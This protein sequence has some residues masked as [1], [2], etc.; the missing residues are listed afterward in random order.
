MRATSTGGSRAPFD[1]FV[2]GA[3]LSLFR[4]AF[5]MTGSVSDAEDA[6][7]ETLL[8]VARRWYRVKSME[9]PTGYARRIL[10]NVVLDG[11]TRRS[12]RNVELGV[13]DGEPGRDDIR[14][15]AAER[16]LRAAESRIDMAAALC[17]LSPRQRAVIVLRYWDDQSES[18]IAATLGCSV[19]TVKSTASRSVARLRTVVLRP[20]VVRSGSADGARAT[21]RGPANTPKDTIPHSRSAQ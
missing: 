20:P 15:P 4:T 18:E 6:V 13:A 3:T 5:L 11:A 7:Q 17:V 16:E 1:A 10:V 21:D 19:G 9:H 12:R 2:A 8:R 14:D